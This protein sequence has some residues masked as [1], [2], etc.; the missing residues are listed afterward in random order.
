MSSS[1]ELVEKL[2][3]TRRQFPATGPNPLINVV[4]VHFWNISWKR[5]SLRR[6][7]DELDGREHRFR[8]FRSSTFG[9]EK[10][11]WNSPS[12]FCYRSVLTTKS[13]L[14]SADLLFLHIW[15]HWSL[16]PS[17]GWV[18]GREARF[19]KVHELYFRPREKIR[20]TRRQ[21]FVIE[22]FWWQNLS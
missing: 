1:F 14:R 10:N 19:S 5:R 16:A 4:F 13:E 2:E 22:A 9:L 11:P 3:E 6:P 17:L 20:G 7:Q 15:K 8:K 12:V 21:F 18:T